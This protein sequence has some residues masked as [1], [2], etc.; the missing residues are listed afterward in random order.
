MVEINNSTVGNNR[1]GEKL[2][3]KIINVQDLI[4]KIQG[5]ILPK[6]NKRTCTIIR[7][8]R[9]NITVLHLFLINKEERFLKHS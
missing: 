6:I 7:D 5:E 8:L 1:I 2:T 4:R 9:V 3:S